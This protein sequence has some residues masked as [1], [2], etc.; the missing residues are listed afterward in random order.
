MGEYTTKT[1]I[2]IIRY[3]MNELNT[4]ATD[5]SDKAEGLMDELGFEE[6]EV[7]IIVSVLADYANMLEGKLNV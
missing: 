1:L 4:L 2:N 3:F 5:H 7:K 6:T